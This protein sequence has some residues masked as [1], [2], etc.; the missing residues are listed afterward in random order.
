MSSKNS[1]TVSNNNPLLT[2]ITHG[3][4]GDASNLSL[5]DRK[6]SYCEDSIFKYSNY[7]MDVRIGAT[8]SGT[9][10]ATWLGNENLV[11]LIL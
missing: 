5:N 3:L 2:V 6:F 11:V 9:E 1:N 10:V 8:T 4:G 7:G